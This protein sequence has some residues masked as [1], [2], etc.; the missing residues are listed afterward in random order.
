MAL[1]KELGY[2]W[3]HP[4][5]LKNLGGNTV[6][7]MILA[8]DN[9]AGTKIMS[10]LYT[11]AAKRIPKMREEALAQQRAV[12]QERLFEMEVEVEPYQY[13]A[14]MDPEEAK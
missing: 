8:T 14:P 4:L 5:E 10:D 12:R 9:R 3:T 7:H 11:D 13:E 2:E 1:E 6:Y